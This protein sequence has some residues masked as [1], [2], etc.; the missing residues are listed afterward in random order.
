MSCS[1]MMGG[2]DG[3][4]NYT[5]VVVT[6]RSCYKEFEVAKGKFQ[7]AACPHGSPNFHLRHFPL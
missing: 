1:A 3:Q 2:R 7:D 4:V 5:E 6:A